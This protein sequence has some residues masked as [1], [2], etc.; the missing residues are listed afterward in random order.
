[1]CGIEET[2]EGTVR[3]G[4]PASYGAYGVAKRI[5]VLDR[6]LSLS[7][8]KLLDLGCGNGSYTQEL[9][10]RADWIC[11]LD[12]QMSNLA[13]FRSAIPRLQGVG[14]DLPFSSASFD[15]ITMIEV[16]EHTVSDAKVLQE[17]MRVL[18]PGGYLILFVPNKL[19][20]MESHPCHVGGFSIGKNVP[21]VS[22]FPDFLRRRICHARIYS[23]RRLLGM[24]RSAGFRVEKIDYVYP[25]VDSF[26]LPARLKEF[27]RRR[28]DSLERGPLRSLG[29]S[30]FTVLQKPT[31]S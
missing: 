28:S 9:M 18:K 13:A 19:Y 21:F 11:G 22:W 12:V 24:A 27:Y 20:P 31:A 15:A 17:C 30:I 10:Q 29:V 23:R 1:M 14:E 6:N 8:M 4:G 7:G 2:V 26:P 3:L 5:G 25:P 16:L